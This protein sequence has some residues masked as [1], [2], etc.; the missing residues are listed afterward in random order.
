MTGKTK[1]AR[2]RAR[3]PNLTL[4]AFRADLRLSCIVSCMVSYLLLWMDGHSYMKE[5]FSLFSCVRLLGP[6]TGILH[7]QFSGLKQTVDILRLLS[8]LSHLTNHSVLVTFCRRLF[9]RHVGWWKR[10]R[11]LVF[12]FLRETLPHLFSLLLSKKPSLY[13]IIEQ[14]F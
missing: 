13:L 8:V 5:N 2:A 4:L 3:V 14:L 10:R 6:F 12:P 1:G 9:L 7:P 11:K